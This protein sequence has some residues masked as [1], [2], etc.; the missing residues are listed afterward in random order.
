[1]LHDR[2]VLIAFS[3]Q[4]SV[5]D[6]MARF[7]ENAGYAAIACWS[8]L[9]DLERAVAVH[10]PAAVLYEL[11][12]PLADEWERFGEARGRPTLAHV[13]LVIATSALPDQYRRFGISEP[14]AVF[15]RPSKPDV[16]AAL[17]AAFE[18]RPRVPDAA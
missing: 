4:P 1:V 9:D 7:L 10:C 12:F 11:G 18:P 2:H 6:F 17:R 5:A 14:L 16:E 3:R 13:P 8:T 15:T